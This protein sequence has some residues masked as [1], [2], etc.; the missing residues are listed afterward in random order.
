MKLS[1]IRAIEIKGLCAVRRYSE[2]AYNVMLH[3]GVKSILPYKYPTVSKVIRSL[4]KFIHKFESTQIGL[5]SGCEKPRANDYT[6]LQ[7][8]ELC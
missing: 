2:A 3:F 8:P 7:S 4:Y 1:F 6:A 5:K